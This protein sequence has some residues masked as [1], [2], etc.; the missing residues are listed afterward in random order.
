MS[1]LVPSALPCSCCKDVDQI[2]RAHGPEALLDWTRKAPPAQ[3]SPNGWIVKLGR[4]ADLDYEKQRKDL[5][6]ELGGIRLSVLDRMRRAGQQATADEDE[7]ETARSRLIAIA[8]E[9][10]LFQD[11]GG[12][13]FCAVE[14]A[15]GA[16]RTFKVEGEAFVDWLLAEY[17]ARYPTKIGERQI[18]GAV[19]AS[20][21]ADAL[22]S[23]VAFARQGETRAVFLRLGW[24]GDRLYLDLGTPEPRAI[25]I[26]LNG[27]SIITDPPVHL[28]FSKTAKPLPVPVPGLRKTVLR[29]LRRFLGFQVKDDRFVLLVGMMMAALL[30]RGPYPILI[31]SGEQGS[32]K[33]SRSR[34]LKV[35]IDPT[36]ASVRG[37]PKSAEDLAISVWRSWIAVFD[38]LS[39]LDQDM[40]DWLCRLSEGA[41]LPKRKLYSDS[42]EI[43]IEAARPILLTAIPD[44]A[45][46]GDVIDRAVLVR[47]DQLPTKTREQVLLDEFEAFR[48][49]LLCYLIEAASCALGRYPEMV[50]SHDGLRRGDWCAWVEAAAPALGVPEGAFSA[51]YRRNQDQAVRMALE[52]DS[53]GG[54]VIAHLA[55][56]HEVETSITSLHQAL[57]GVVRSQHS[58]R[59]P[60][61]WPSMAHHFSGRLRRLAPCCVGSGSKLSRC[62]PGPAVA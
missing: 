32:G 35:A 19:N 6:E 55:T 51:A 60:L 10:D 41:G 42:E 7:D 46:S 25:E 23:I 14:Q 36:K 3:L 4:M 29:Q 53:V 37:R 56:K 58:G 27:W 18:P 16:I 61:D 21:R 9:H 22:R 59:L 1:V 11:D 52:L 17:G 40:S 30:P 57:E 38:N 34:F 8:V 28:V 26:S 31:L 49:Q 5:A 24:G 12:D 50:D 33:T 44:I 39:K 54:A 13:A 20:A 2:L 15:G 62:I 48:P 47:C 43:L 45:R